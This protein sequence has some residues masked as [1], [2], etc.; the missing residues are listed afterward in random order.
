MKELLQIFTGAIGTLAIS[1]IFNAHRKHLP[2]L[3]LGAAL[4][5]LVY[6]IS[7]EFFT[8][9]VAAYFIA[10]LVTALYAEIMARIIRTPTTGILI[11]SAL[12]LVPGGALYYTMRFAISKS[13]ESFTESALYTLS[14]AFAIAMGIITV[15]TIVKLVFS[16]KKKVDIK[17]IYH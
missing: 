16:I 4:S 17:K 7:A 15:S 3:T 10:S 5:W 1:V 6:I 14:V 8:S 12:P 11:P 13:K 9:Q 2:F